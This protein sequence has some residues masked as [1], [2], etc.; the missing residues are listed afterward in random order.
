[1]LPS[2][3]LLPLLLRDQMQLQLPWC[4]PL[5]HRWSLRWFPNL[6]LTIW[7]FTIEDAAALHSVLLRIFLL[8]RRH[9]QLLLPR[10]LQRPLYRRLKR[11][12][13]LP[14]RQLA[15]PRSARLRRALTLTAAAAA[16]A[17]NQDLDA[18]Q[19]G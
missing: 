18:H 8:Q 17:A 2:M 10:L 15:I 3:R 19:L 16:A 11:P 5:H 7:W 6:N 13:A 14:L 1:M 9:L 4:S 12:A